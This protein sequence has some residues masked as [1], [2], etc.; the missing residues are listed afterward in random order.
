MAELYFNDPV[1]VDTLIA[2]G[3]KLH[4]L[5]DVLKLDQLH[6]LDD[7]SIGLELLMGHLICN[8]RLG[9]EALGGFGALMGLEKEFSQLFP[10]GATLSL[11]ARD[12]H[13]RASVSLKG[14]HSYEMRIVGLAGADGPSGLMIAAT[15]DEAHG[16]MYEM[17][18][19]LGT[20]NLVAATADYI[21]DLADHAVQ[22]P[23]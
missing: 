12:R 3:E 16:T 1:S 20:P 22:R 6:Q 8:A 13:R 18:P 23:N 11:S 17:V 10:T 2:D 14:N 4:A 7:A 15:P 5:P 21:I 9:N 19:K